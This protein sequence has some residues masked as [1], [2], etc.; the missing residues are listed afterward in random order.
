MHLLRITA[1]LVL[2]ACGSSSRPAPAGP[3]AGTPPSPPPA[4]ANQVA[5]PTAPTSPPAAPEP[6]PLAEAPAWTPTTP[7][8]HVAKVLP[9][10]PADARFVAGLDIPRLAATPLGDK[11]RGVFLDAMDKLPASCTAI[12]ATKLGEMV[13]AGA[14]VATPNAVSTGNAAVA[15]AGRGLLERELV[16]C[17][18]DIMKSKGG[19]LKSK[20]VAGRTFHFATGT[21]KDNGWVT[22]TKEGVP[23]IAGSEAW[24]TATLDPKAPKIAPALADLASRADHGR[25]FWAAMEI[26]PALLRDL[27]L[28]DSLLTA[29]AGVRAGVDLA[30]EFELD[31][32]ATFSAAADANRIAAL[33]RAQIGELRR[34]PPMAAFLSNVRLGLHGTELRVIVRLDAATSEMLLAILGLK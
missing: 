3:T 12:S 9:Q 6:P 16:P 19:E 22:W 31:V 25:M 20:K 18:K 30:Q 15:I 23:Y 34:N 33:L 14:G 24:L 4:E 29:P 27:G 26:T 13:M 28:P 7:R 10:L 2:I 5:D 8:P 11:L 21:A 32:V 1:A 17:A